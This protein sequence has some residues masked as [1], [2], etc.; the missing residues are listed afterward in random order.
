MIWYNLCLNCNCCNH[1]PRKSGSRNK[2]RMS[3]VSNDYVCQTTNTYVVSTISTHRHDDWRYDIERT[4]VCSCKTWNLTSL[5]MEAKEF[6]I[7]SCVFVCSPHE[8]NELGVSLLDLWLSHICIEKTMNRGMGEVQSC[9][10][11]WRKNV[12]DYFK[13]WNDWAGRKPSIWA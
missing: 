5:I 13:R 4:C 10:L 11:C 9:A 8:H 6:W 1:S 12:K 3:W 2:I 7:E